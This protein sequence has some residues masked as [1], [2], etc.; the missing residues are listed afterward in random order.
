MSG[1][2][3]EAMAIAVENASVVL[4]C[5]TK[6]YKESPNCR[7]EAEYTMALKKQFIPLILEDYKPDGWL[8]FMLGTKLY[9]KIDEANFET[10]MNNV[11]KELG[12]LIKPNKESAGATPNTDASQS[13]PSAKSIDKW[14]VQDVMEWLEKD[15]VLIVFKQKFEEEH[16][17]GKAL[18]ELAHMV[19]KV[20]NALSF[21]NDEFGR[22]KAGEYLELLYALRKLH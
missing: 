9:Y 10:K 4:V 11:F 14:K 18:L 1:S 19:S 6:K 13:Q 2:I 22:R 17:T 5:M 8:G 16:I 21:L 15:E 20:P 7:S 3:T 12:G